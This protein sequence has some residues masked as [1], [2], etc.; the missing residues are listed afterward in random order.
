[1][2]APGG[3]IGAKIYQA[4]RDSLSTLWSR[5]CA[6]PDDPVRGDLP[7]RCDR[8]WY[9]QTFCE[10]AA[11]LPPGAD[12]FDA[13]WPM[14]QSVNLYSPIAVIGA[15]PFTTFK[16]FLHSAALDVR[17]ATHHVIG[18]DENS[19]TVTDP[20]LL[21]ILFVQE[22]YYSSIVNE[23]EF[24]QDLPPPLPVA[25]SD[26]EGRTGEATPSKWSAIKLW[27]F[28]EQQRESLRKHVLDNTW[29]LAK[30]HATSDDDGDDSA[31]ADAAAGAPPMA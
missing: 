31:Q 18:L 1:M 7:A 10:G 17:S 27:D 23:S 5:V 11:K 25:F 29:S 26:D 6:A 16:N 8:A 19:R 3:L 15:M 24:V 22:I 2:A 13:V 30:Q 21:R 9:I 20:Q 4:E 28:T 12:E 14:V